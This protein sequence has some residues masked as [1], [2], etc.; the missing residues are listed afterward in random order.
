MQKL[1]EKAD[2]VINLT[3]ILVN[4]FFWL[5]QLNEMPPDVNTSLDGATYP[6]WKM[7][8]FVSQKIFLKCQKCGRLSSGTSE[9][10]CSWWSLI[11]RNSP[12]LSFHLLFP[13][14]NLFRWN[15]GHVTDFCKTTSDNK[16]SFRAGK[17]FAAK[18][19]RAS[20]GRRR[21]GWRKCVNPY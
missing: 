16:F 7:S 15:S 9:A 12:Q 1:A 6:G 5:N 19:H 8:Q 14:L 3:S 10:I 4:P 17:F 2:T 20:F 18:L 11:I 13:R 21:I